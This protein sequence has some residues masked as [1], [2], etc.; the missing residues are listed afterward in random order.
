MRKDWEGLCPNLHELAEKLIFERIPLSM[1]KC[2]GW[3]SYSPW[4]Y[5]PLNID[6]IFDYR[7]NV[8]DHNIHT[9]FST[10]FPTLFSS[11]NPTSSFLSTSDAT[12]PY[13]VSSYSSQIENSSQLIHSTDSS[14]LK[15]WISLSSL[16]PQYS[17]SLLSVLLLIFLSALF[18]YTKLLSFFL[19]PYF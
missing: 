14:S 10:T 13:S 11:S 2:S 9:H 1:F 12:L 6:S 16:C 8:T 17:Y 18:Y 4:V 15:A 7:I 3:S 19:T 5:A